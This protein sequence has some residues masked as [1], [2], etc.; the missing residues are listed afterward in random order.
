[1]PFLVKFYIRLDPNRLGQ[2]KTIVEGFSFKVKPLTNYAIPTATDGI[3]CEKIFSDN[4][5]LKAIDNERS[6]GF[7][8]GV[9]TVI[10]MWDKVESKKAL[11][12]ILISS[13]VI[14]GTIYGITYKFSPDLPFWSIFVLAGIPSI[15]S[16][17][18]QL[19]YKFFK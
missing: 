14:F 3:M 10:I 11:I 16:F 7:I 12:P 4:D 2:I 17:F 9:R 18:S 1:M 13:G 8:D 19:S 15:I 6:L 5:A